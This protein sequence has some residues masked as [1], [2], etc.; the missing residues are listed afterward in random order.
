MR[1][2]PWRRC[3]LGEL[4]LSGP[5]GGGREGEEGE[6]FLPRITQ[7]LSKTCTQ[8]EGEPASKSRPE[9]VQNALTSDADEPDGGVLR[10]PQRFLHGESRGG[11]KTDLI[12]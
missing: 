8:S 7:A 4:G 5:A 9:Q 10:W 6:T 1:W 11:P 3:A 12:P 2:A